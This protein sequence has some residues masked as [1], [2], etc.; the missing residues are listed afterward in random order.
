MQLRHRQIRSVV[1]HAGAD[2]DEIRL[3]VE[4]LRIDHRAEAI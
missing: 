1:I 2:V 4:I 3:V